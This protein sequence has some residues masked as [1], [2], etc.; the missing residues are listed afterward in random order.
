MKEEKPTSVQ[1]SQA[2]R[3]TEAARL[4]GT[5]KDEAAFKAKLTAIARQKVK[6]AAS[7]KRK[8]DQK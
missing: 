7:T 2:E 6:D 4:L 5:D 8:E 1:L 3:F